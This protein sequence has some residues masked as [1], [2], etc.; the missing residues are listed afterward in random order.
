MNPDGVSYLDIAGA[1]ARG[2]WSAAL[3]PYW[4]PLYPWLLGAA[5]AVLRPDAYWE[6]AV[7]HGVNL[8][9][10]LA[11]LAAF[12]A[13]LAEWLRAGRV[14]PGEAP[15]LPNWALAGLAYAAFAWTS[16]RLVTVSFVTPDMCVAALAFLAAALVL[17]IRRLGPAPRRS[18]ALGLVL[19]LGYLAKAV[20]LPLGLVVLLASALAA[21]EWGRARRHLALAAAGFA[22]VA[23]PFV[24]ALSVAQGRLTT[25][26]T[27]RLNYAWYV[28]GVPR[29]HAPAGGLAHAP[30]RLMEAPEVYECD[31]PVRGTYPLWYDPSYWYEG[32]RPEV[33]LGAQL[34]AVGR[35]MASYFGL[36]GEQLLGLTGAV[37]L[38]CAFTLLTGGGSW[39]GRLGGLLRGLAGQYPVL[40]PA[41]AAVGLYALVG[42]VE[43]RLIGPFLV[44]L[45]VGVVG[46]LRVPRGQEW[47]TARLAAA[48]LAGLLLLLGVN[49]AFDAGNAASAVA[50]GEGPAAHPDWQA[51]RVLGDRGLQPGDGVAFVGFTFDA[52]WARLGGYRVV[53]EVPEAEAERFWAQDADGRA[54]VLEAF[55]RAGAR[56][57]VSRHPAGPGWQA[58]PGTGYAFRL[59]ADCPHA[60]FALVPASGAEQRGGTGRIETGLS[61][62]PDPGY[63]SPFTPQPA[64]A[65]RSR[66][67]RQDSQEAR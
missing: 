31:G 1:C 24:A 57:V 62:P 30:R 44:L 50:R 64:A 67:D 25:G 6:C 33:R 32:L 47:A 56:A 63:T 38:L 17:R 41:A 42:H 58:V 8:A 48:C 18:L 60:S 40:M 34:R 35:S 45:G 36:L 10:F 3:N 23:A 13:L 49:L 54:A 15:R 2:D 21:R 39:R 14:R 5:L 16:R 29:P 7:V 26:E 19:G 27:G 65:S 46:A 43:G 55:H 28:G 22:L 4:S 52:Y 51:A 37:A 11:A 9:I 20:L 59:L 61:R 12:E 66:K 53:A